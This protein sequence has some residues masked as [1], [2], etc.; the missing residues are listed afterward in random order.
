M[1]VWIL[2]FELRFR[3]FWISD[4]LIL[5]IGITLFHLNF[6]FLVLDLGFGILDLMVWI[7]HFCSGF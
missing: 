7:L 5:D 2:N 3:S 1:E 4:F 6:V